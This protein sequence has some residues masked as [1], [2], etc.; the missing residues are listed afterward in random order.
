MTVL[1]DLVNV[2][3][4]TYSGYDIGI[5]GQQGNI[6][7]Q[8]IQGTNGQQGT[9]G[10]QGA[11]GAGGVGGQQG[12]QG[13]T[14]TGTQGA[15]GTAG[16]NGTNGTN[17]SQGA[18]GGTGNQGATG[19]AGQQGTQGA[20]GGTGGVGNQGAAGSNGSNGA[21]GATGAQGTTGTTGTG[22]S[23]IS[24]A[25]NNA[26]VISNGTSNSATTNSS[27]YVSGNTIYADAFYQN[28]SRALK[29][30]IIAFDDD[31]IALL[32]RVSVVTFYY[33]NDT[34][35]PHIGFIAEDTPVELSGVNQNMMDVPSVVGTLIKAVQQL[36]AQNDSLVAR[37]EALENK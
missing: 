15:T 14:G 25:N 23:T 8:G 27:I 21:Q 24:P 20:T 19:G 18:A 26:L 30:N 4:G 12:A 32:K 36:Q 35:T 13:A 22:F 29:T 37:I 2:P 1:I 6:G 31:A 7:L 34:F 10:I 16:T 33:K 3:G 11:Q 28:S 9:Q 5:T 17:G